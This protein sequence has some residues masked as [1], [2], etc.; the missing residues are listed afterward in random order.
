MLDEK[1]LK[2]SKEKEKALREL[3]EKVRYLCSWY[4]IS[5]M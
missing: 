5:Y 2:R 1:G 4:V 3:A